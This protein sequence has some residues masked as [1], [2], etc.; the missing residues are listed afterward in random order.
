MPGGLI[1]LVAYG[2]EDIYLT[3]EPQ[4]TYFKSVYRRYTPF[5]IESVQQQISNRPNWGTNH[6]LIIE[7]VGDLVGRIWIEAQLP[8][9]TFT[10]SDPLTEVEGW[11][12]SVGHYLVQEAS[13][14][15]GGQ[16]LDRHYS[17]WMEVWQEL[18]LAGEKDEGYGNMIGKDLPYYSITEPVLIDNKCVDRKLRI[19]LQF[20]FCRNPGLA[21]PLI[22]LQYQGLTLHF[23][24]SSLDK[25]VFARN[26]T[27]YITPNTSLTDILLPQLSVWVD[28]FFLD[29]TER[30]KF[31]QHPHEYLVEQVQVPIRKAVLDGTDMQEVSLREINHPVTEIVWLWERQPPPVVSPAQPVSIPRNDFSLGA[32][33]TLPQG[34][35]QADSPLEWVD[36]LF[37]K[38][39]RFNRR[40]GE[41]FRLC[42]PYEYH[43]RMPRN[44]IYSYSFALKPEDHQPSGT[45]N[46][47]RLND[48]EFRFAFRG[49]V[50][51]AP[52][53]WMFAVNYNILRFSSGMAGLAYSN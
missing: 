29:T 11:I 39:L 16:V 5:A 53:M 3:G 41:Y 36:L 50:T 1:Q 46:F 9:I 20:W 49:G 52:L 6:D 51:Q 43:T 8:N 48:V 19:P 31:A 28:Y 26:E 33:A 47:S 30:R 38:T 15:I 7:R 40:D 24:L 2:A 34:N 37:N 44:Y 21:I 23:T 14:S 22:A 32:G 27:E 12:Q 45:A 10:P 42:Q 13:I 35:P 17:H 4:V 18:T 25:L